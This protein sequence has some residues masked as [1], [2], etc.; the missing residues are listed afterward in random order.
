MEVGADFMFS[1]E[2]IC[3]KAWL[4]KQAAFGRRVFDPNFW[5]G[6]ILWCITRLHFH[7]GLGFLIFGLPPV[8]CLPP[9]RVTALRR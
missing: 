8:H 3:K 9:M 1:R 6:Q 5:D 2:V 7:A 4:C